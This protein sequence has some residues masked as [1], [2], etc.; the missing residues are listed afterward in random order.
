M[1]S[2]ES[3]IKEYRGRAAGVWYLL[4][5][6]VI[7]IKRSNVRHKNRSYP[8]C[9]IFFLNMAD[10]SHNLSMAILQHVN[11]LSVGTVLGYN[12]MNCSTNKS[13]VLVLCRHGQSGKQ[14][15]QA[16]MQSQ[17]VRH[18]IATEVHCHPEFSSLIGPN[19]VS[20]AWQNGEW[21]RSSCIWTFEPVSSQPEIPLSLYN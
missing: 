19:V 21:I 5:D 13:L 4:S 16:R 8:E 14:H 18:C 6:L 12:A 7:V 3:S 1:K 9:S 17:E 10:C 15:S 11:K 20:V 2:T